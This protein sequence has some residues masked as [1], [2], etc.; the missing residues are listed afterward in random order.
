MS[1]CRLTTANTALPRVTKPPV[2]ADGR[3][4]NGWTPE[5]IGNRLIRGGP[6][7]RVCKE[8]IYRDS[9]SKEGVAPEPW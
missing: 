8:T 6:P 9:Y 2:G 5:Q 3:I 4:K 7:L 1:A